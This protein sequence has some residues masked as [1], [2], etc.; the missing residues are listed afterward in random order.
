MEFLSPDQEDTPQNRPSR[1]KLQHISTGQT[2]ANEI[3]RELFRAN[4][5]KNY[6]AMLGLSP[7]KQSEDKKEAVRHQ[8]RGTVYKPTL[9]SV[10]MLDKL[11]DV[12]ASKFQFDVTFST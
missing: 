5:Q 1:P 12:Y 6:T 11:I 2:E 7:L 10:G 9:F 8:R 4:S 3:L